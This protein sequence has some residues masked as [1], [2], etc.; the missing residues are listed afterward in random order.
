[1][2]TIPLTV[3]SLVF[4]LAILVLILSNAGTHAIAFQVAGVGVLAGAAIVCVV[5]GRVRLQRLTVFDYL[6]ITI[7]FFSLIASVINQDAYIFAYSLVFMATYGAIIILVRTMSDDEI[8]FAVTVSITISIL[9]VFGVYGKDILTSLRPGAANRWEL[10]F[11][12]FDMTPDLVGYGFGG[13]VV[14]L[15]FSNFS[16]VPGLRQMGLAAR[17]GLAGM[18]AMITLAASAR[19][20]LLAV[21][22][23]L[24]FYA[25]RTVLFHKKYRV[26]LIF[27]LVA[28]V[29]GTAVYWTK[30]SAYMTEMLEL[31]SNT[32]GLESGGSGRLD[33]WA[34]GI[35]YVFGRSWELLIGSGLR[36]SNPDT[37]GFSTESSYITLLIEQG[38]FLPCF[39]VAAFL[40]LLYKT[41]KKEFAGNDAFSRM[42]F[43]CLIF[44]MLQSIFNRYLIAIGNQFSLMFLVIISR[45]FLDQ[46]LERRAVLSPRRQRSFKGSMEP[47]AHGGR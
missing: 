42:A 12:P 8:M 7:V 40:Y 19:A 6:V 33:L 21:F 1:M 43:Y 17:L 44:A 9:V 3:R 26:Y 4:I 11:Q 25:A 31:D 30:I 20:G 27:A 16:N 5:T 34:Q 24:A 13:F 46:A 37:I 15:L 22:L 29:V 36:S 18:A 47:A 35:E 45:A 10:R 2:R 14:V 23:T 41:G 39:L 38:L 28:L 32:R